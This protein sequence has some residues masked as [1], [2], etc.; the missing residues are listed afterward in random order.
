M[1]LTDGAN[2]IDASRAT[3]IKEMTLVLLDLTVQMELMV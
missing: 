3:G 1:N 2:G